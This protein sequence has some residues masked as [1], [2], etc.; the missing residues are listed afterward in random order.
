MASRGMQM[1]NHA[2]ILQM[3]GICKAMQ[4]DA[5]CLLDARPRRDYRAGSAADSLFAVGATVRLLVLYSPQIGSELYLQTVLLPSVNRH[6]CKGCHV[7]EPL[8]QTVC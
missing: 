4:N 1:E 3:I 8:H 5:G 7:L 2:A 6:R